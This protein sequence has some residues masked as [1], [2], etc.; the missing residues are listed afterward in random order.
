MQQEDC[1]V[2]AYPGRSQFRF[3][4][5]RS[6]RRGITLAIG[7]AALLCGFTLSLAGCGGRTAPATW[8]IATAT[9]QGGRGGQSGGSGGQSAAAHG[10]GATSAVTGSTGSSWSS[11]GSGAIRCG[12]GSSAFCAYVERD[13]LN[14]GDCGRACSSGEY[15][16]AGSCRLAAACTKSGGTGQANLGVVDLGGWPAVPTPVI[17][18][19][20]TSIALGDL[21]GDSVLDL[22]VADGLES[23][24]VFLGVGNGTFRPRLE[25][26]RSVAPDSVG[27][28]ELNGDGKLDVVVAGAGTLGVFYGQGDGT[29]VT[30][31]EYETA[32]NRTVTEMAI[33][34]LDGDGRA[35]VVVADG[36][37]S[38]AEYDPGG[39][40]VSVF[41]GQGN[42]T[43]SPSGELFVDIL[44]AP[45]VAVGDLNGDGSLDLVVAGLDARASDIENP[46]D[47][48]KLT[49]FYGRGEGAFGAPV[50]HLGLYPIDAVAIRD[51][52]QDGIGDVVL[53]NH[54]YPWGSQAGNAT[55]V[56]LGKSDGTL[57][58]SKGYGTGGWY[59][60]ALA[61]V[62]LDDDG[63]PD[64]VA[65]KGWTAELEL[66][67]GNG[68]GSLTP[69][70]SYGA[71]YSPSSIVAGDLNGDRVIDLAVADSKANH[72]GFLIG[73][74]QGTF[75][76]P[77]WARDG[78]PIETQ[79]TD[80][81]GV[82]YPSIAISDLNRDGWA[83]L[84]LAD[85][86]GH[87]VR[88]CLGKGDGTFTLQAAYP[89]PGEPF[90]LTSVD[91]NG[92]GWSDLLATIYPEQ[93]DSG[94]PDA[95]AG[96]SSDQSGTVSVL[97][98]QAS[99]GFTP[100]EQFKVGIW[101]SWVLAGPL[102][103]TGDIDQDGHADVV[104]ASSGTTQGVVTARLGNGDGSFGPP[105]ER[106][107]GLSLQSVAVGD[108][109][110]D[111]WPDLGLANTG[112]LPDE[113]GSVIVLH[114]LGNGEFG[115][116]IEYPC[117]CSP[118]VL[119]ITDLNRDG[120]ADLVITHLATSTVGVLFGKG[121]GEFGSEIEY[122]L[123]GLSKPRCDQ[124]A[125]SY[126]N[127]LSVADFNG[128]GLLDLAV[129]NAG[130]GTVS[131]LYG[132]ADGSF[133]DNASYSTA[134]NA[135]EEFIDGLAMG[136]LNND[137]RP[138]LVCGFAHGLS[139]LM[140]TC[141]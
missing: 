12:S 112:R 114:G 58:S 4:S 133:L 18:W 47:T 45:S 46:E 129:L 90:F 115:A 116:P 70:A 74:G 79:A 87:D 140:N 44:F 94:W 14:C 103:A 89:L 104:T 118:G 30:G 77:G 85:T 52:D 59:S 134:A 55:T 78:F 101:P 31:P 42:G 92:D 40:T 96:G 36:P 28:V 82:G 66:Y 6:R 33:E 10:G 8:E 141:R 110:G 60:S 113:N 25:Y 19:S 131:L 5:S 21:S 71:G 54:R 86:K 84:A 98:G 32:S 72:V 99:G 37:D 53:A 120:W 26:A 75:T 23:F 93:D 124:A 20:R 107:V 68:D 56:L 24:G 29:F 100:G 48:G 15:C 136:D 67:M 102:L 117:A 69:R 91:L 17:S 7:T 34:D 50:D 80:P 64:V 88:I 11:C 3:M 128:D 49:V 139:V 65:S 38:Y 106:A 111:G 13:P 135:N 125:S 73:Q 108:L 121:H 16:A 1:R 35:D 2:G 9:P 27:L 97:L 130:F 119:L 109:N 122:C 51:L 126:P 138:D 132:Q 81:C 105:A 39:T 95:S 127:E 123:N 137:G 63:I 41:L 61:V 62:D 57:A 22:V 43:L 83:D 76:N